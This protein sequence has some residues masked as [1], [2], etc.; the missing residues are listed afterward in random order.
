M[1]LWRSASPQPAH[2]DP[3]EQNAGV[4]AEIGKIML[5]QC[6]KRCRVADA[7]IAISPAVMKVNQTGAPPT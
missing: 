1:G 5:V 3:H 7:A 6:Q 2:T 4:I